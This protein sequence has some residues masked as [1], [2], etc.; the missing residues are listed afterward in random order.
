MAFNEATDISG[1]VMDPAGIHTA[2]WGLTLT[3][4]DMA[5]IGQLYLNG[6]VWKD[7]QIVSKEWIKDSTS[8]HSRW[9][10]RDLPYGYLW[11][12]NKDGYAAVGDGENTI[13]VNT[14]EKMVIAMTALFVPNA[15]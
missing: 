2:G 14:R 5:K 8:E 9:R 11:W 6:G 13:Y 7:R 12:V 15:R 10:K 4:T 1:W 3:A